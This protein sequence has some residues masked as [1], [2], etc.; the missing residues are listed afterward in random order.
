MIHLAPYVLT[1]KEEIKD[2]RE[3]LKFD[4]FLLPT[5]LEALVIYEDSATGCTSHVASLQNFAYELKL[6]QTCMPWHY[7]T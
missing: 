7:S 6:I 1:W 2:G 4:G 3:R 5:R